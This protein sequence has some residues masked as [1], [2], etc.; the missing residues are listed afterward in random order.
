MNYVYVLQSTKDG[1]LYT[2]CTGDLKKRFAQHNKGQVAA[3]RGREPFVLISMRHALASTMPFAGRNTSKQP[4][5]SVT[6]KI[7][8]KPISQAES[9]ASRARSPQEF[10]AKVEL[11]AQEADETQYWLERLKSE[12]GIKPNQTGPISKEADELISIFVTMAKNTKS[13]R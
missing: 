4:M 7:G 3:T 11:C 12:C 1:L 8:A 13:N 6:L 2:G 5:G 10:V 9:E